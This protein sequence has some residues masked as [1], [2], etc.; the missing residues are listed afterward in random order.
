MTLDKFTEKNLLEFSEF[1]K[2]RNS[3]YVEWLKN[4]LTIATAILAV[5]ISLKS[6]K[7]NTCIESLFY[8]STILLSGIGILCGIIVLYSYV[9]VENLAVKVKKE[10]VLTLLDGKDIETVEVLVLPKIYIFL[11]YVCNI[12]LFLSLISLLI[13]GFV[14]ETDLPTHVCTYCGFS[15]ITVS[16]HNSAKQKIERL[17]S[18]QQVQAWER[19]WQDYHISIENQCFKNKK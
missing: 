13:Y 9:E 1:Q 8:L 6:Q 15:G 19:W 11:E 3:I 16:H 14:S 12:S 4:L 18:P 2:R 10:Q 17:R 7:S 5:L